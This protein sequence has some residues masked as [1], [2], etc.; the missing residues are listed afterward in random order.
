MSMA[1]KG[2]HVYL[3]PFSI[4]SSNWVNRL[5][6]INGIKRVFK[7]KVIKD[8]CGSD[9]LQFCLLLCN[10]FDKRALQD[11]FKVY[12]GKL[13]LL[14]TK[15]EQELLSQKYSYERLLDIFSLYF[16]YHDIIKEVKNLYSTNGAL[17][18]KKLQNDNNNNGNPPGNS[19]SE[20]LMEQEKFLPLFS[21][22]TNIKKY[23][24]HVLLKIQIIMLERNG[25]YD[26]KFQ[27]FNPASVITENFEGEY[28][29]QI[30]QDS[31]LIV[32]C[33][34]CIEARILMNSMQRYYK[35]HHDCFLRD[36]DNLINQAEDEDND[37]DY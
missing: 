24:L 2:E 10:D 22:K 16:F 4:V 15:T 32:Q 35:S 11:V 6:F 25:H 14:C 3:K 8:F 37:F 30:N 31:L 29:K 13:N 33:K 19:K 20:S 9:F 28:G 17:V 1:V 34:Y 21:D 23:E 12:N 26:H 36:V 5:Q 18:D 27:T 7:E